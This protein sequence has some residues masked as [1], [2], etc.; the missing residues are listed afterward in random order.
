[1]VKDVDA[2]SKKLTS[3][4]PSCQNTKSVSAYEHLRDTDVGTQQGSSPSV[5]A[6]TPAQNSF[7]E[8]YSDDSLD[9]SGPMVFSVVVYVLSK[10]INLWEILYCKVTN[11]DNTY[12]SLKYSPIQTSH[13]K[14]L[15]ENLYWCQ[16]LR[17]LM[18]TFPIPSLYMTWTPTMGISF[19]TTATQLRNIPHQ[20][21]GINRTYQDMVPH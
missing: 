12:P 5:V 21:I 19:C 1:M 16:P 9:S 4:R 6:S 2:F 10:A 3:I 20:E 15:T 13:L 7:V 8:L 11:S 18:K 14:T 17:P